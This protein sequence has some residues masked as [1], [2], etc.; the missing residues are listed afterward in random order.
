M[1]AR[2]KVGM[3]IMNKTLETVEYFN[4]KM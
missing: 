3:L 4:A 2:K 1:M